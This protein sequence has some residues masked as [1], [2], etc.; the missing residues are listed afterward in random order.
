[1]GSIIERLLKKSKKVKE[2][3]KNQ[4]EKKKNYKKKKRKQRNKDQKNL[5]PQS[6]TPVPSSPPSPLYPSDCPLLVSFFL[7]SAID[8]FFSQPRL[9]IAT[10][11]KQ[12]KILIFLQE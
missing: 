2:R 7:F 6:P 8:L 1:V 3:T 4:Q 10:A 5:N 9:I 12:S 11:M